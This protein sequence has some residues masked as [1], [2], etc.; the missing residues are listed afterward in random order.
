MLLKVGV[1]MTFVHTKA[2]CKSQ[3]SRF[4]QL[5]YEWDD[6]EESSNNP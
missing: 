5:F 6:L 2:E 3:R 1:A 4:K